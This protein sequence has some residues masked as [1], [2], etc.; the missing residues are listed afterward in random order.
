MESVTVK[1]DVLK[2]LIEINNDRIEGY[3]KAIDEL[4]GGEPDLQELFSEMIAESSQ[5]KDELTRQLFEEGEDTDTGTTASGKIYRAWMDVKA[6]FGGND[7]NT[8]LS[9]CEGG[10]DA[11]KKAYTSAEETEDLPAETR[12][13][14]SEQRQQQKRSHDRIKALRDAAI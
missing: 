6:F 10:E 1:S 9:N 13:L 8:I 4:N 11:A 14:I 7:R 2:D 12:M 5:F 3:Q